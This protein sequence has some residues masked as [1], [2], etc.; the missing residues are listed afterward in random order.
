MAN[1][2]I[3]RLL[4]EETG[5]TYLQAARYFIFGAIPTIV[6]M[7]LLWI[8]K[9]SFGSELLLL[10]TALAFIVATFVQYYFSIRFVFNS[11]NVSSKTLEILV[12]FAVR[13]GGLG[14]TELLMWLFAV[15]MGMHY[16][17]AKFIIVILVFVWNFSMNKVLL[18]RNN[19]D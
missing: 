7:G 3:H 6:D 19:K 5:N 9:A 4:I 18:F 10:W 12:F 1:N 15:K 11:R 16:M 2:F 13:A 14:W 17:L 8:L